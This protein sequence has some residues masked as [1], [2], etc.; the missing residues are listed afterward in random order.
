MPIRPENKSRY[1]DNWKE[2]SEHIRFVR[3]NNKC[4]VCGVKNHELGGRDSNGK[5]HKAHALEEK[6]LKLVWPKPGQEWWCGD[7]KNPLFLKI[8]R[9]VLTV[10]HLDHTPE[11]CDHENLKAMCQACHLRYDH[12]LHL[13]NRVRCQNTADMFSGKTGSPHDWGKDENA[14]KP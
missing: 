5:W 12:N 6:R 3:A 13:T 8:V 10:A 1:P 4:E 11:N 7:S 14:D 9:I 2:I